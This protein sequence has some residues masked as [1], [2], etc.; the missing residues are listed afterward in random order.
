MKRSFATSRYRKMPPY[1]RVGEEMQDEK[2][3]R[4]IFGLEIGMEGGTSP[5][6]K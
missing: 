1:I 6:H 4:E 5:S 2:I 3:A